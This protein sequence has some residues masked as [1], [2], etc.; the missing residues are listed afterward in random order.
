MPAALDNT[1]AVNT[2]FPPFTLR[3][4]MVKEAAEAVQAEPLVTNLMESEADSPA[5][6]MLKVALVPPVSVAGV[7][8]VTPR[9]TRLVVPTQYE[10]DNP[11]TWWHTV[12]EPGLWVQ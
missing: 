2:V 4:P 11:A 7:K 9:T 10:H 8:L 3:A 5:P 6:C 1:L 12:Y